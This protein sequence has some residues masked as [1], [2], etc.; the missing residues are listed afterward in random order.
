MRLEP[1]SI[2]RSEP[3]A[4]FLTWST[5]GSWLPGDSRGW[6]D[7]HG[8]MRPPN[9]R[10]RRFVAGTLRG[11]PVILASAQ[12]Q[13]VERAVAEQCGFRV[14]TLHAVNC[15]TSHVHAVVTASGRRPDEVLR[16]LKAW[17]SRQLSQ[18]RKRSRTWWSRGGSVR[19]MFDMHAVESVIAYVREC[20]DKPRG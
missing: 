10:L 8:V 16:H 2:P 15:R 12:R 14:W 19:W 13:L 3:V 6:V 4:F 9:D 18:G 17:C 20:Q 7:N 1:G 11:P 5:Y